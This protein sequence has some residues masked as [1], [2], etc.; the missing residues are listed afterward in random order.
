MFTEKEALDILVKEKKQRPY[1][2]VI[3]P[4]AYV[5]VMDKNDSIYYAV[6][7]STKKVSPFSPSLDLLQFGSA[8]VHIY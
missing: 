4:Y 1:S 7:R 5:F 8:V 3:M 6:S 2:C